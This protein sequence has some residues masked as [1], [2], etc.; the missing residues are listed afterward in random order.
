MKIVYGGRGND[1]FKAN[2]VAEIFMGGAGADAVD[3]SATSAGIVVSL[4]NKYGDNK[5]FGRGGAAGDKFASIENMIGSGFDDWIGGTA[6]SNTLLGLAGDDTIWGFGGEDNIN[7]ADGIDQ[8]FGGDGR[9]QIFGG[10]G[11]D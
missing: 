2:P 4:D 11:N 3:Y 1:R 7:G 5:P 8:L 9:D 10:G 6:G